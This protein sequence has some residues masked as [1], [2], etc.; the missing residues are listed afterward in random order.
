[1]IKIHKITSKILKQKRTFSVFIPEGFNGPFQVIYMHDGQNLFFKES[2]YVGEIWDIHTQAL[3]LMK[4][5]LMEP[6][7]I[8]GIDHTKFRMDEYSPFDNS[9][10]YETYPDE[11]RVPYY[12]D[13]YID[14]IVKELKPWIDSK[15][16]TKLESKYTTLAGSSLGGLISLYGGLFYP[17][18]F[19]NIGLFS[20]SAWWNETGLDALLNI[21]RP[22]PDQYF[23]VTC[24]SN[25]SGTLDAK[26]NRRYIHTTKKIQKSLRAS[27]KHIFYKV[28][29]GGRHNEPFWASQMSEFLQFINKK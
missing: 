21:K 14:F 4:A 15:Y 10:I 23:Y 8:V 27:N 17:H 3:R 12:G 13:S 26:H 24:G 29:D 6:T 5:G 7:L 16:P 19:G 28:Y 1:M 9:K 25:E 18:I 2:S 20:T 22:L 11:L